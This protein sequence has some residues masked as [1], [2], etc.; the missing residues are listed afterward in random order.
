[1]IRHLADAD[2][3]EAAVLITESIQYADAQAKINTGNPDALAFPNTVSRNW[4]AADVLGLKAFF[5]TSAAY[6]ENGRMMSVT[7]AKIADGVFRPIIGGTRISEIIPAEHEAYLYMPLRLLVPRAIAAGVTE[8]ATLYD[9]RHANLAASLRRFSNANSSTIKKVGNLEEYRTPFILTE[10][11]A[12]SALLEGRN[13]A[14]GGGE[15]GDV[16]PIGE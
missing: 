3:A 10:I 9:P 11:M 15:T 12:K 4:T 16:T 13:D 5:P 6:F 8:Q 2:A 7:I 14:T 1:M